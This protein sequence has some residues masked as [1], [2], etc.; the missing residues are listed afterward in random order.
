MI[1]IKAYSQQPHCEKVFANFGQE[2][3]QSDCLNYLKGNAVGNLY[4]LDNA[5]NKE[6]FAASNTIL[7]KENDH[8]ELLAGEATRLK[9]I[10]ALR[11]QFSK[12]EIIVLLENGDVYTYLSHIL[13][14]VGP[15][16][17]LKNTELYGAVDVDAFESSL[18][19]LNNATKRLLFFKREANSHA[20]ES[21]RFDQLER[22]IELSPH[23]EYQSM[24]VDSVSGLIYLLTTKG[25]LLEWIKDKETFKV[26][27]QGL[28][29]DSLD[30]NSIKGALILRTPSSEE[31][32]K[33]R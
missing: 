14:N 13:G 22:L 23:Y 3:I 5:Q 25:E 11:P 21:H 18:L 6:V 8:E 2:E 20:Q 31:E 17:T 30:F 10:I 15:K 7:V 28:T 33:L 27:R 1:S 16:R 12:K 19:V 4:R 9:N 24:S 29:A 32:L 26:I